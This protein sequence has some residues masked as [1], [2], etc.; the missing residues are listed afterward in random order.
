M[1]AH[2]TT[3]ALRKRSVRRRR[4]TN[5]KIQAM[6]IRTTAAQTP[7]AAT[8]S[9]AVDHSV[10]PVEHR[11]QLQADEREQDGVEDEDEDAGPERETLQA[12]GGVVSSGVCQPR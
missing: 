3:V 4:Y 2:A 5:P 12:G 9:A 11:G 6:R 1:P 10:E 7:A 8:A